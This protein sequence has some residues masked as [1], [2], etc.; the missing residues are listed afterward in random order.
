MIDRTAAP[1]GNGIIRQKMPIKALSMRLE[2]KVINHYIV[3]RINAH[4]GV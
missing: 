3:S 4:L 2:Q 1:C